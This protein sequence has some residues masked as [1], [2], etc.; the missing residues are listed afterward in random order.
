MEAR[1]NTDKTDWTDFPY[2]ENHE[3]VI[4]VQRAR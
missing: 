2:L 4:S 3:D 1:L